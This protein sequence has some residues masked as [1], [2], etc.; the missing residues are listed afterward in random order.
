[1]FKT[2][3]AHSAVT[4]R[5]DSVVG[6]GGYLE[7]Y[8]YAEDYELW[9]RLLQIGNIGSLSESLLKYDVGVG[10]VSR[11][12]ANEQR[13]IHCRIAEN[14]MRRLIDSEIE[15]NVVESL[16][17]GVESG[18][19]FGGFSEF[20][21]V[22]GCLATLYQKFLSVERTRQDEVVS[23]EVRS[24]LEERACKLVRMLPYRER[25]RGLNMITKALPSKTISRRS[26]ARMLCLP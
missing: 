2:P 5:R 12:K 24:D 4:F 15:N 21:S 25:F 3:V 14:N 18:A 13:V 16:A 19:M 8:R 9:S 26:M 7:D 20:V 23:G 22:A 10:G 17:F 11:A 6:V 1:M